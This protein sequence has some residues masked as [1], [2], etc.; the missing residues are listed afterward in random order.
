MSKWQ[1]T[2]TTWM[3]VCFFSKFNNDVGEYI[4]SEFFYDV[5]STLKYDWCCEAIKD[6]QKSRNKDRLDGEFKHTITMSKEQLDMLESSNQ[7]SK[8][9][10]RAIFMIQ[11]SAVKKRTYTKPKPHPIKSSHIDKMMR[12]KTE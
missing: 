1:G 4:E 6:Q 8:K 5:I 11:D 7:A 3:K 10:G 9:N 2:S 12:K